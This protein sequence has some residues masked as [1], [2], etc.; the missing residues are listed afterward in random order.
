MQ[1]TNADALEFCISNDLMVGHGTGLRNRRV[2]R[3]EVCR[4]AQ[5]EFTMIE[6]YQAYGKLRNEDDGFAEQM[7]WRRDR[8]NRGGLPR[9]FNAQSIDFTPPVAQRAT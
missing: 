3:N 5:P 1:L 7:V 8:Q 9:E 2:Y 6:I 4:R